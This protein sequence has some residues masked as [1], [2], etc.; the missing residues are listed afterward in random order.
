MIKCH[1]PCLWPLGIT[2][3]RLVCNGGR[4]AVESNGPGMHPQMSSPARYSSTTDGCWWADVIL[5]VAVLRRMLSEKLMQN[6]DFSPV[7]IYWVNAPSRCQDSARAHASTDKCRCARSCP[8]TKVYAQQVCCVLVHPCNTCR[9]DR[10][11]GGGGGEA[12]AVLLVY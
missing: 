5:C 2:P 10:E 4:P 1:F 9:V 12:L 3:K 8:V 11:G 6:L 7:Q